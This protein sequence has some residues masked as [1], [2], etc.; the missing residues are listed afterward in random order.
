LQKL[1]WRDAQLLVHDAAQ[2]PRTQLTLRGD[3]LQAGPIVNQPLLDAMG[4][5]MRDAVRI[6]DRRGARRQLRAAAQAWAE[7]LFLGGFSSVKETAVFLHRRL[8]RADRPAVNARRGDADE[9]H[10]VKS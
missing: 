7:T 8:R 3:L 4:D 5:Q 2:L 6:I 9:K 10:A 1:N